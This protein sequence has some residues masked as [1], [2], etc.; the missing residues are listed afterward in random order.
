MIIGLCGRKGVGKDLAADYLVSHHGF[1]K[2][3]FADP[4]KEIVRIAFRLSPEQ[5]LGDA[6]EVPD[7][8]HGLSP[9]QM[10]QVIGTDFFRDQIHPEFWVHRAIHEM[11]AHPDGQGIVVTDIRFQNELDA[12][13][14]LGGKILRIHRPVHSDQENGRHAVYDPHVSEESVDRLV[15]VDAVVN[16][17]GTIDQ[18]LERVERAAC[19]SK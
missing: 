11:Q 10:M 12:V 17:D 7:P 16:N 2:M 14:S 6:K 19:G 5:L 15:G 13:R 1:A 4:I 3:A 8:R 9:R 18:F